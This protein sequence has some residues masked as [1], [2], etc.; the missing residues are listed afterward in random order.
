MKITIEPED[1]R[2]KKVLENISQEPSMK[3]LMRGGNVVYDKINEF[4]LFGLRMDTIY[5]TH[6]NI[7][8]GTPDYLRGRLFCL[9]EDI[10]GK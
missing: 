8:S 7:Q 3:K 4:M 9:L 6:F 10:K 1:D 5:P 2:D